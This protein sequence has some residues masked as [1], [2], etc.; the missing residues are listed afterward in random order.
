LQSQVQQ[1]DVGN[2][3]YQIAAK[4]NSRIEEPVQQ[5]EQCILFIFGGRGVTSHGDSF[6]HG[7]AT[8]GRGPWIP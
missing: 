8:G 3:Y 5:F 6:Q 1:L 7:A 2:R 4:D